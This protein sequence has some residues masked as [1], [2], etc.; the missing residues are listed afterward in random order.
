MYRLFA[1]L[2]GVCVMLLVAAQ[3]I[4]LGTLIFLITPLKFVTW[5]R[6]RSRVVGVLERIAHRGW[7]AFNGWIMRHL[8]PTRWTIRGDE[9]VTRGR[10]YLLMANHRS[11]NDLFAMMV[12]FTNHVPPYKVFI[13]QQL[14]WLP[15]VGQVVWALDFPFM[16]RY[17]REQIE[18][19]PG[20]KGRDVETTRRMFARYGDRQVT[21]FNFVEG[22]RITPAKHAAQQSPYRHLLKPRAG[23]VAYAIRAIGDKLD[24]VLDV[25]FYYVGGPWSFWDLF[26]GLVPEVIVDVREIQP[27]AAIAEGDYS[28]DDAAREAAQAWITEIWND[29]DALLEQLAAEHGDRA[30]V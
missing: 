6:W 29:K 25:T 4:V 30:R 2:R 3:T 11:W 19:D 24:A 8:L 9:H 14:I 7:C 20:L 15:I 21:I 27:P 23:G 17:T 12:A 1:Q 28:T 22:T 18:A 26:C 13:K 5:G 16:K 10:T